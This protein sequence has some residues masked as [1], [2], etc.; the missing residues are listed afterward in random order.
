MINRRD[1]C[2]IL[3]GSAAASSTSFAAT[4]SADVIVYGA[5]SAGLAT[6]MQVAR[7][8]RTVI[9]LNPGT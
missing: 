9:V 2:R 8:G 1:T 7:M 4:Q 6:A 5:T 3:I